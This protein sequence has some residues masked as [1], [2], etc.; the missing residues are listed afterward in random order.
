MSES[1]ASIMRQIDD[2]KTKALEIKKAEKAEALNQVRALIE[3]HGLE[4]D[5][6]MKLFKGSRA[7]AAGVKAPPKYRDPSSGD[8]WSGRGRVPGW[9][10]AHLAAGKTRDDFLI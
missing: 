1:Y 7:T 2:L 5:D 3:A 4:S 8:T 9:L 6:V 10:N